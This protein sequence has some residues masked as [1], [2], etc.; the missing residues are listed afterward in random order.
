MA[1]PKWLDVAL[2]EVGI[3]ETSGSGITPRIKEYYTAAGSPGIKDDA[4]AWCSAFMCYVIEKAGFPS[5]NNLAARS[6][7][8][9]GK[10]T[11]AKP[12]AVV[13]LKRGSSSWQGH[14]TMVLKVDEAR[15][16]IYC[17]GGNQ[18]NRVNKQ[19]YPMNK[20]LGYRWPNTAGN[21]VTLA[22]AGGTGTGLSLASFAELIDKAQVIADQYSVYIDWMQYV[23]LGLAAAG[24]GFMTYRHIGRIYK[25][26]RKQ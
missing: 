4:V 16:R 19:W 20:A 25:W 26:A 2:H 6:W 1:N 10:P 14:V 23:G 9:W 21:S 24:L 15:Q 11:T 3:A 5:T 18:S 22:S 17:V 12:G 13:I 7:L 8:K